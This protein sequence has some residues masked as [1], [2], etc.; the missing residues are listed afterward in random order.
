MRQ[1]PLYDASR[2]LPFGRLGY[3]SHMGHAALTNSKR[4]FMV[5]HQRYSQYHGEIEISVTEGTFTAVTQPQFP[6]LRECGF[7]FDPSATKPAEGKFVF[8][9]NG[10][11]FL[12]KKAI[13]HFELP[14]LIGSSDRVA[15][16]SAG[17]VTLRPTAIDLHGEST[18]LAREPYYVP[19]DV[20][21]IAAHLGMALSKELEEA[22]DY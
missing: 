19:L 2:H 3:Y 18:S 21:G 20:A 9:K 16:L 4:E 7:E 10:T 17:F 13:P 15:V 22:L 6:V 8:M 12:A 5:G 11:F 1:L 14:E